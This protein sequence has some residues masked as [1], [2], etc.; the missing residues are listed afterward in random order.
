MMK[1]PRFVLAVLLAF[2]LAGCSSASRIHET[3]TETP[4]GNRGIPDIAPEGRITE[5]FVTNE[6]DSSLPVMTA[7]SPPIL[8]TLVQGNA[9]PPSTPNS[10]SLQNWQT[11]TSTTLGVAADYPSDWSVAEKTDGAIFTSPQ[12]TT[13]LFEA[14]ETNADNNETR[15]GN[16]YCTSRTNSHDLIAD[17]CVDH[18]SFSY[19]AEFTVE[20]AD[21][22][23]RRFTLTTKSRSTG[24]VFEAMFNS[25]R[26]TE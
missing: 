25:V 6:A 1:T 4:E 26:L 18:S 9:T 3:T 15:I 19:T 23:T 21:G 17:I 5:V 7:D 10:P 11:F 24:H 13:I 16:Q 2:G 22:S 8:L 20:L 12:S 14:V